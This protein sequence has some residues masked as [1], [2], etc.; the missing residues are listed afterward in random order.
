M[1]LNVPLPGNERTVDSGAYFQRSPSAVPQ[2]NQQNL[3]MIFMRFETNLYSTQRLAYASDMSSIALT[4][5][6]M[7]ETSI[8]GTNTGEASTQFEPIAR[9]YRERPTQVA[10]VASL[11]LHALLIALVPG[12]RSVPL[13]TPPVL[14]V[15]IVTEEIAAVEVP[16]ERIPAVEPIPEPQPVVREPEPLPQP[17]PDLSKPVPRPRVIEQP[18]VRPVPIAEPQPMPVLRQPEVP[19]VEPVARAEIAP[20]VRREIPQVRPVITRR[21]ELAPA[22][23]S[24][25]N[26]ET[27]PV[28]DIEQPVRQMPDISRQPRQITQAMPPVRVQPLTDVPPPVVQ[29]PQV[30]PVAPSVI[31]APALATPI[32][33]APSA[34]AVKAS[35]P[36]PTQNVPPS[37]SVPARPASPSS[38]LTSPAPVAPVVRAAP[39]RPAQAAAPQVPSPA[40]PAPAAVAPAPLVAAPIPPAPVL[41]AVAP[42]VIEAYRQA[43]SQEIMRHMSYPRIAVM[44][45]WQGK[46]VVEMQL[47]AD[48]S[49]T[50]MVVVESSGKKVLDEAALKMVKQ[51]LPLPKPPR[52]VRTVKVPVVFRLQG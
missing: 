15:Q 5:T 30:A 28:A 41:E 38:V 52:G 31:E 22:Q 46:A 29:A 12:F 49:V 11:V 9:W 47:S 17:A 36:R 21:P 48:G 39:S 13:D 1:P 51:S 40:Q 6:T 26:I 24:V 43:I 16:A 20:T 27:P 4:K 44:R 34:P 18:L 10:F 32:A 33:R 50:Q 23:P 3:L 25:P 42:S 45:K 8:G 14:T 19:A 37:V 2:K 35:A 7:G